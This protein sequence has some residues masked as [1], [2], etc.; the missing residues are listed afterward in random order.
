MR[1]AEERYFTTSD[2]TRLFYRYWPP[3]GGHLSQTVVLFHRGHEHS[4]RLQHIVDELD[5]P[6]TAMFAWD[7]RGHGRSVDPLTEQ[8]KS[9]PATMGT[10]V[11]DVDEFVHHVSSEFGFALTDIAL[12][13]QSVGSV[14]VATW[15]HDY[16][17]PVRCMILA[18]P[19]FSVKLYVPFARPALGSSTEFLETFT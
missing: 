11:K 14:L 5:L 17:P 19:A 7:A 2:G 3:I 6:S 12:L 1:T 16:A 15:V 4:G 13:G 9:N 18:S 10:L 8:T